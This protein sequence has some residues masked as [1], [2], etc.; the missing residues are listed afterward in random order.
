MF[1]KLTNEQKETLLKTLALF[2]VQSNEKV[3]LLES[4]TKYAAESFDQTVETKM[5]DG[6]VIFER[7]QNKKEKRKN[8]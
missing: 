8:G 2:A 5:E 7:K 1:D 4:F 6:V 3:E